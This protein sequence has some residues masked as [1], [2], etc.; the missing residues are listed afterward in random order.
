MAHYN[1]KPIKCQ[2]YNHNILEGAVSIIYF[3]VDY[4]KGEKM[5]ILLQ[6]VL[7]VAGF[8]LLIKGADIFVDGASKIASM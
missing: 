7:L 2:Y 3:Y 5:E 8:A 6:L 1:I 4:E